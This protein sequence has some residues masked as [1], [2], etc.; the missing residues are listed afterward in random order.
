MDPMFFASSFLSSVEFLWNLLQNQ[1]LQEKVQP[2]L[3]IDWG[4][5]REHLS[6]HGVTAFP[7]S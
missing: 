4:P 6:S 2:A 5:N 1:G 3:L 7:I